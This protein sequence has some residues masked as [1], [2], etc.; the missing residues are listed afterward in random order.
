MIEN[1]FQLPIFFNEQKKKI[2]E[3][4]ME[5]LELVVSRDDTLKP[6]YDHFFDLE[7]KEEFTNS[8]LTKSVEYYTTDIAFLKDNQEL[9]KKY[10]PFLHEYID[11][12]KKIKINKY[13]SIQKCWSEIKQ[14]TGFKEKY[15]FID[16]PMWEFLNKSDLFLQCMSIYNMAS[17]VISL[18]LPIIMLLIPFL[19]IQIKGLRLSVTEYIEVLK[20]I[21]SQ[22]AIGKIFTE[23][24]EVSFQQKFYLILSAAFYIFSIYQNILLCIRFHQN[25]GKIHAYFKEIDDYL[26]Y[27]LK[28]MDHYLT[29]SDKL[30]SHQAFTTV[31]IQKKSILACLKEN[32]HSVTEYKWTIKKTMEIG[33][34]LKNFYEI[35]EN[36][37]YEDCFLYSFGFHGY[38]D[39]LDGIKRN[40]N[41]SNIH[42]IDFIA[43]EG[44]EGKEGKKGKVGKEGKDDT[45]FKKLYYAALKDKNPVKNN[46]KLNKNIII[47]GPNASGK[48]TILK[49]TMINILLSQQFGCGFYGDG[50]MLKPYDFFH[51]YLNIPDTS[52]RDS[53]FQAEARRCK[54]II[55]FIKKNPSSEN[56][57]CVFDELYSGT[58]PEEAESSAFSFMEYL[59]KNKNVSTILTTH[60]TNICEKLKTNKKIINYQMNIDEMKNK[61]DFKYNYRLIKGISTKKGGIKVLSDMNYPKEII[62]KVIRY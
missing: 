54:E 38:L 1:H 55:D 50:S 30:I 34:I 15:Y 9:L 42:F 2:K 51:C 47:T 49:S 22:H 12:E 20:I 21:M 44:K 18:L 7:E 60:Y 59:V 35:Y 26:D 11:N 62:E 43:K 5:D 39:C 28:R 56:H 13:E 17:P 10:E 3:N 33:F 31:L 37:T 61:K 46:V 16:W 53:L 27:S 25:M 23:F 32:I 6:I 48:T 19:I 36:E 41:K 29:Y 58:N 24:N 4:L 57:F 40:L 52:G 14:D 8:C 45:I